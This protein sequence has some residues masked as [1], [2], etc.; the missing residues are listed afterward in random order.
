LTGCYD[1]FKCPYFLATF[2]YS[3]PPAFSDG[4]HRDDTPILSR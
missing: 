1:D 2:P 4:V 3:S